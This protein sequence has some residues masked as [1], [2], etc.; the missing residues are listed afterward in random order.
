MDDRLPPSPL[1][2]QPMRVSIPAQQGHLEEEHAARPDR[3]GTA[4]PG[5]Y[6][7]GDQGLHLKEQKRAEQ[8]GR[9]EEQR[10]DPPGSAGVFIDTRGRR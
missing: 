6:E 2:I 1:A 5:Q 10:R 4:E 8:N 7:L 3:G 9:G